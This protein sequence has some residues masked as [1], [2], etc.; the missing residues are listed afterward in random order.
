MKP[1]CLIFLL[2]LTSSAQGEFETLIEWQRL[3]FTEFDDYVVENNIIGNVRVYGDEAFVTV[4]RWR[5][6]VPSTL[7]SLNLAHLNNVLSP[8]KLRPFPDLP[9]NRVG[10]CNALQNVAAIEIDPDSGNL[11]VMDSGT[12]AIF[13]RPSRKCPAKLVNIDLTTGGSAAA[14]MEVVHIFPEEIVSKNS[15]IMHMVMDFS[16]KKPD[17]LWI[18]MSDIVQGRLIAYSLAKDE[19]F[20]IISE[21]HMS[22]TNTGIEIEGELVYLHFGVTGLALQQSS[23]LD[24]QVQVYQIMSILSI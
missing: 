9:S 7:N 2:C 6:G 21:E 5:N 22:A 4:P 18:Y 20:A 3:E 12:A 1:N 15:V 13:S 17:D 16:S 10:N 23:V 24:D 14:N 11:W 19:S 8:P